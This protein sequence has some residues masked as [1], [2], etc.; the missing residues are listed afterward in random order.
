MTRRIFE[1]VDCD[2]RSDDL[3]RQLY[4]T[5]ASIYQIVP[6]A[7]AFPRG[8]DES[9]A[10]I[11][12]AGDAGVP[13]TARGSG[14]GLAG[15]AIGDGLVID[16][17]RH[18]RK[19]S[20]FDPERRAVSVEAGVVLDQLN[21]FLKPHGLIFGPDV[22]TSSRATIGGMIGS[23][24]S[25]ARAPLYGTTADHVLSLDL[26]MAD[27]SQVR[28]GK[29][30]DALAE[31]HA[32]IARIVDEHREL[33]EKHFPPGL[34][35]RW[36]GYGFAQWLRH[37][38]DLS[39]IIAGSEGTLAAVTSA[40]LKLVPLPKRKGV[41]L[42][43]FAS[44]GEAMQACVELLELKPAA[45]EHV[46]RI[47]LDQTRGQRAFAAARS[48]L[49]LDDEPCEAVL[50]VEFYDDVDGPLA[51]MKRK[52]L[53]LRTITT[54][55]QTEMDLFWS[56]RKAGV[57]LLAGCKGPAKTV[58]GLEDMAVLP[59]KLP[60]FVEGFQ[61]LIKP[62]G[63]RSSFYGHAA[64]GLLHIRPI[65]DLHDAADIAKFRKLAGEASELVA[66][67]K[68]S[69][70][71]EHGVGIA[72]AEFMERQIGPEL[73]DAMRQIK[74]MFDPRGL[75]NPGKVFPDGGHKIDAD[76]RWGA[77]YKIELPFEPVLAFA[78][79]DESFVGNLEQCNG[80]A[81]CRKETPTMCPT[82][83]VTG[84][85]IMST[86]GRAN[87]I[88]AVLDGRIASGDVPAVCRTELAEALDYCL[89]CKACKTECPSNVD[90]ALLKAELLNARNNE[91]GVGLLE[92]MVSRVD[93]LMALG[94]ATP[95][96]ANMVIGWK[97][98]R[99]LLEKAVGF[100]AK[101]PLP[102]YAPQRFDRWFA[103]RNPAPKLNRGRVVLWD[104]CF[105]QGYEPEIG[106]AAVKVLEA[107]G[108]EVSLLKGHKCCGRPAFSTGRLD[109]AARFGRHN[110]SMLLREGSGD[111]IV[112]LEPSCYSMF[113][114]DY[115]ELGIEG[116]DQVG[117]RCMLFE[118]FVEGVLENEPGAL[119]LGG[120]GR[121]PVAVHAH[122][123]AKALTD[124]QVQAKLASRVPN[125]DV[126]L[127]DSACC[128]MAGA[129]GAMRSKYEMSVEV[130][131][132]LVEMINAL[133]KETRLLA[134]GTSCRQ[135]ISHLTEAKPLHIAEFLA[136]RILD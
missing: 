72:R 52:N 24:S 47:L 79:K 64:S 39:Q 110:V 27:G 14:S 88:R 21:A 95:G 6:R 53:G 70:A 20:D 98:V 54:T 17:F 93:L 29:E 111:P 11:K 43:F 1:K 114:E 106:K 18:N 82:F 104:D 99:I 67:F 100:S 118:H 23:N 68:G 73:L 56:V 65:V 102:E 26:V 2:V 60:E 25:G 33:I 128:G 5:D 44:I 80:C 127:L 120:N 38:S 16:F 126:E 19:I 86:R 91:R 55:D 76:L 42:V 115:A 10:V 49:N 108:Y 22:A 57:A 12:A 32:A 113:V 62:L 122:C 75:M 36:P 103:G 63:L 83:I 124:V 85:E 61:G 66:Q 87:T 4:A 77:G 50:A 71:A 119:R 46:D 81:G 31:H 30:S 105:T 78:R 8:V 132:P 37:S 96:L 134:S 35:K 136:G 131:R 7:V 45:I 3:T 125:S 69:F 74:D 90:M 129:Y 84:D 116:A 28:V 51:D 40:E 59:E 135:Q 13:I 107:A 41:G 34:V 89:S 133:D 48:F 58:A 94:C 109:L 97:W 112:F 117:R 15:A 101:R 123:H 92:R 121:L 130:A 9:V